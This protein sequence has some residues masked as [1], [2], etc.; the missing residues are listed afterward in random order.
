MA[1]LAMAIVR[2][3]SGEIFTT[4]T[5]KNKNIVFAIASAIA[6]AASSASAAV[7]ALKGEAEI[8]ATLSPN[9]ISN[10][11]VAYQLDTTL[12]DG[13]KLDGAQFVV[14]LGNQP[15]TMGFVLSTGNS[16]YRVIL[17]SQS[18]LA[19][20]TENG[21]ATG[22]T[23]IEAYWG[24][25]YVFPNNGTPVGTLTALSWLEANMGQEIT[26][27]LFDL[28]PS[29]ALR[30]KETPDSMAFRAYAVPE[31]STVLLSVV[32]ILLFARRRR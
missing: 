32:S 10:S 12:L 24:N 19:E 7:N 26:V 15:S 3:I 22:N 23:L 1:A 4:T 9:Q 8:L 20:T 29:D 28:S 31:P 18:I 17:G 5:M 25:E 30:L 6:L 21:T 14:T 2:P 11:S 16:M 27:V 13:W